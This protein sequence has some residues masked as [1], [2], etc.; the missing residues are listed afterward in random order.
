MRYAEAKPSAAAADS[1]VLGVL[2]LANALNVSGRVL[3]D[4]CLA[5]IEALRKV[6]TVSLHLL[7]F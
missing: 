5:P 3:V 1:A 6:F 4:G 7:A 2:D